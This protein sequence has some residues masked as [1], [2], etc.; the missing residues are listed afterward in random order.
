MKMSTNKSYCDICDEYGPIVIE[1]R[2]ETHTY[3]GKKFNIELNVECCGLCGI[4][5]WSPGLERKLE[6]MLENLYNQSLQLPEAENEAWVL[7]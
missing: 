2:T 7:D 3:R 1:K 5:Q 4:D 6:K